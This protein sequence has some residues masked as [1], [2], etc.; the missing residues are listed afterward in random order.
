MLNYIEHS[1][2][3]PIQRKKQNISEGLLVFIR[4]AEA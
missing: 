1:S 4:T 2:E 3:N